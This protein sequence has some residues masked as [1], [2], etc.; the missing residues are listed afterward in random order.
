MYRSSLIVVAG[1]AWL[2][3]GCASARWHSYAQQKA[4]PKAVQLATSSSAPPAGLVCR[5][6]APTGSLLQKK[7]CHSQIEWDRI[8]AATE[9]DYNV[10][11]ARSSAATSTYGYG[12]SMGAH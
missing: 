7:E 4:P 1:L 11:A 3:T 9:N 5:V 10:Q 2:L 8:E 6:E 12:P